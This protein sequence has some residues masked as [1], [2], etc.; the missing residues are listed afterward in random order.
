M[1]NEIQ[2]LQKKIDKILSKNK[3]Q[4]FSNIWQKWINGHLHELNKIWR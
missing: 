3:D 2:E 1:Q 4:L